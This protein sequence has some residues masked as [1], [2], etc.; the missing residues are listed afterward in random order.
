M[1]PDTFLKTKIVIP[2]LRGN[3]IHRPRIINKLNEGLN[4]KLVLI[5]AP[6]GYGKTLLLLDWIG[7]LNIPVAWFSIDPQDNDISRYYSYLI[8]A[9]QKIFPQFGHNLYKSLQSIQL[10]VFETIVTD[11]IDEFIKLDSEFLLV[12]DDYHFIKS[13]EII[14]ST[15]F[16]LDNLPENI[17]IAIASRFG[18]PFTI[19]SYRA[20]NQVVEI[21]L[22]D[23][24]FTPAETKAFFRQVMGIEIDHKM[25]QLLEATIEGWAAGL[26]LFSL[27]VKDASRVDRFIEYFK[28]GHPY[29]SEYLANEVINEQP[30]EIKSFLYTTSFLK[31]FNNSLCD[32]VTQRKDSQSIIHQIMTK[33]MFI[34]NLDHEQY[35]FRYHHLF[36]DLLKTR[37]QQHFSKQAQTEILNRAAIWFVANGN[38]EEAIDYFLAAQNYEKTVEIIEEMGWNFLSNG[39][40]ATLLTWLDEI[41]ESL[42]LP[43]SSLWGMRVWSQIDT[44][45]VADA[46]T[47]LTRV[48]D[49]IESSMDDSP[50]WHATLAL[51]AQLQI[52]IAMHIHLDFDEVTKYSHE[53]LKYLL[54]TDR[55]GQG[56]VYL[57]LGNAQMNQGDMDQADETLAKAVRLCRQSNNKITAILSMSNRGE[58]EEACGKLELARKWYELAS[59]Q[60]Q[61]NGLT[62][63]LFFSKTNIGL[64]RLYLETMNIHRATLFLNK[65]LALARR[66]GFLDHLLPGL[67]TAVDLSLSVGD[68]ESAKE[69]LWE[70]QTVL[71]NYKNFRFSKG[72]TDTLAARIAL[73]SLD[74]GLLM[75]WI[76]KRFAESI[77]LDS[78]FSFFEME[79]YLRALIELGEPDRALRE[80][81]KPLEATINN[82][83]M[84]NYY[85]LLCLKVNALM[86]TGQE[87][88]AYE[89]LRQVI[90][91]TYS[92]DLLRSYLLMG[93]S[94]PSILM[95]LSKEFSASNCSPRFKPQIDCIQKIISAFHQQ[96]QPDKLKRSLE[97]IQSLTERETEILRCISDG[98][99]N[100]Q[101][102]EKLF[103]ELSTVKWHLSNI[104]RKLGATNR[105]QALKIGRELA[106]L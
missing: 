46:E 79:T 80:I 50:K 96:K 73:K 99:T 102:S 68:I 7:S 66:S 12:L 33:N 27:S 58:L 88:S 18:L 71:L 67:I 39:R 44:G 64:S 97:L 30:D 15:A 72:I 10:P 47:E 98:L 106:I 31:Q 78:Y 48:M 38:Y 22:S 94:A 56:I 85:R 35:W 83:F 51:I 5:S 93:D 37:A 62:E 28:G 20:Q 32:F 1:V 104:Y 91:L 49:N 57:H 101:V 69:H 41:Q 6:A 103:I 90:H 11:L 82:R 24:R 34:I 105:T 95:E 53:C 75:D 81:Q 26:H 70:C 16:M 3:I 54:P 21:E 65:G 40:A 100:Q 86:K 42:I 87:K 14:E 76:K 61:I 4:K 60:A 59:E 55:N 8:I 63:A 84:L 77:K 92:I 89:K 2:P 9:I 19:A 52:L 43:P 45:K 13:Q 23:M 25:S 17:H 36:S 74:R 29:I